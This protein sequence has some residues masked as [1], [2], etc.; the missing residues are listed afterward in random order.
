[1]RPGDE[2]IHCTHLNDEAWQLIKDRGGRTSHSPPLEMAMAHGMPAIQDALDHG[3]RPS[4]S[5]DHT[6]TVAQDMFGIMRTTFNP[7]RLFV[8]QRARRGEDDLPS[9]LTPRDA[10][11]R[12]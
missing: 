11:R 8:L 2:Y 1:L 3:V 12:T 4:L 6:A 7:Q 9:L 5:S 10:S